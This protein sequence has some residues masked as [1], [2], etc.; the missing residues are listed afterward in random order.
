[1]SARRS[2]PVGRFSSLA[3]VFLVVT[4]FVAG[5]PAGAAHTP[6]GLGTAESFAIL[7]GSG[8]TNTG[9]TT[10]TG[11]IGSFP[12]TSQTGMGTVVQTGTNH[13]GD[14]VT[15]GAKN[16]LVTAYNDV[17]GRLPVIDL[18]GPELG[19]RVLTAGVYTDVGSGTLGLT[20]QL[21][22][23]A[24]GDEHAMFIFK[25]ASTL[26]TA[27]SSSVLLVNGADPCRIAWQVG[28]SATFNSG[29]QFAGD[30]IA[31]TSISANAGATFRGRLLARN[32]AVTLINNT[33]TAAAC[34]GV[35]VG[36]PTTVAQVTTSTTAATTTSTSTTSTT[37][38]V[39][40]AGSPGLPP[41]QIV[42]P[43]TGTPGGPPP[44]T[45]GGPPTRPTLPVTGSGLLVLAVA[46]FGLVAIG[47][48][49]L[50]VERRSRARGT[51]A[52]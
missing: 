1:M 24:Q 11:D 13:A 35:P 22:L 42:P 39:S 19:G 30:V 20:G 27:T 21:T 34:N 36:T 26:I 38:P 2:R 49:T 5:S 41:F 32:G 48:A 23:D 12:T 46:G 25:A 28:S 16:D 8:I 44:G 10:I 17:A 15:A 14:A 3:I 40:I 29:T 6:V 43:P 37:V 9:A 33:I 31:L 52:S 51:V 47:A 7:A 50:Q 4:V 45:P 18:A